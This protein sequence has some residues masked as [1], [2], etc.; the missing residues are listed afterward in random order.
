MFPFVYADL[1][2]STLCLLKI[3]PADIPSLGT[4]YFVQLVQTVSN[5]NQQF[6]RAVLGGS[7]IAQA[8]Y[9]SIPGATVCNNG[10]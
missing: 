2:V 9:T 3:Q 7:M 4:L 6:L 1:L 5:T 8:A 10:T